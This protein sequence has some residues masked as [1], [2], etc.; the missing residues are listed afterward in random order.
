[1]PCFPGF[2]P[3]MKFVHETLEMVGI[4]DRIAAIVPP[5]ASAARFGAMPRAIRSSTSGSPTPSRPITATRAAG[6][7][8]RPRGRSRSRRPSLDLL[9]GDPDD[10]GNGRDAP[11]DLLPPVVAQRPH[12]ELHGGILD[13]VGGG[14]L[15]DQLAD[16]L[17]H[18]QELEDARA[19]AVA[20]VGAVL[21][22]ATLKH[23]DGAAGLPDDLAHRLDSE[24][25]R[26]PAF[27]A[28]AADEPLRQ[29][30]E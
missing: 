28:D 17:V 8:P 26:L 22:A 20:G 6:A 18:R 10:F 11:A 7:S 1:M 30:T 5:R 23:L 3:V 15:E 29:H 24:L 27:L 4:D 13:D 19:A 25:R 9:L 16:G 12:A 21:A 2:R 14:A